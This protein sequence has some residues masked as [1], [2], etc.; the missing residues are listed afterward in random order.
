MTRLRV[1]DRLDR[2]GLRGY[3][4]KIMATAFVG[5]HIPLIALAAF[6]AVQSSLDWEA[7]A[8]TMAITLG[9]TLAGT[10]LTLFLLNELLRP[11]SLVSRA[12]RAYRARRELVALPSCYRDE[13]GT[14][15]ADAGETMAHLEHAMVVLETVDPATGLSNR[16]RAL[17]LIEDRATG[18]E[19]FAV[20][21]MRFGS[22]AR[23]DEALGLEHAQAGAVVL[24]ERL[25]R[26]LE[27]SGAHGGDVL[28]RVSPSEFALILAVSE[29]GEEA[30][31][32]AFERLRWLIDACSDEITV[33]DARILPELSCGVAL[34]PSDAGDAGPLLDHAA[35]A[36]ACSGPGAP[37]VPHSPRAR[38]AAEARFRMEA[39]LRRTIARGE[40]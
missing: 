11:V 3:R 30:D 14:L 16:T 7:F 40:L 18:G 4:A 29:V 9:A 39:E 27:R 20:A 34:F 28:A 17:D 32:A 2:L 26:G 24:A 6:F 8:W 22:F 31:A 33:G 23:I 12:L 1:Y 38:I 21:V 36:A 19:G 35:A 10:G 5:T 37:V 25:R 13:V 15:M